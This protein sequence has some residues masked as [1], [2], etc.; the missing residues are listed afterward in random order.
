MHV[1]LPLP[2]RRAPA[3]A[4][5]LPLIVFGLGLAPAG[6][7]QAQPAR[8]AVQLP[9]VTVPGAAP[10]E[11]ATG[12]VQG[13]VAK[14][15]ATATKTDTP[16]LETPQSITVITRDRMSLLGAQTVRDAANYTAGVDSSVVTDTTV[17]W[18]KI[19]GTTASQYLDGMISTVAHYNNTRVDPYALERMEV[20]RGP[21]GMLFGQGALGGSVNLI[22][23]R[24]KAEAAREI[25][26]SYGNHDRKQIQAD[27]TGPLDDEG[28]WLY[29]LVALGRD[30]GSE[31][32]HS[33]DNRMFVA[34]SLTW[35]P[36]AATSFTLL[37]NLQE[38]DAGNTIGYFPWVGTVTPTPSGAIDRSTFVGEPDFNTM[39][40]RQRAVG[41][42]FEHAFND[43]LTVRQHLRYIRS[44][45]KAH[46]I[47]ATGWV[48][49][50]DRLL[51]RSLL[52]SDSELSYWVVDNQA[53]L[54]L[55][56]GPVNHTV[57]TGLDYQNSNT[58]SHR[59]LGGKAEPIDAFE[60]VY[61]RYTPP[62]RVSDS[63]YHTGQMGVYAQEQLDWQRWLLTL[64]LRHDSYRTSW[65]QSVHALTKRFGLMYR[66]A[67]GLNPYLSY[68]ES[69]EG[70]SGTNI[71]GEPYKPLRGNQWEAGIK[72]QPPGHNL[73]VTAAIFDMKERNRKVPGLVNGIPTQVQTGLARTRGF[74]LE[75]LASQG[76][77]DLI[78]NYTYLDARITQGK[79]AEQGH[80]LASIARHMA[81]LWASYRFRVLGAPGFLAGA[82][83]RYNGS[84]SDGA[85]QHGLPPVMVY[86]AVLA[87]DAGQ[88]RM[89]LNLNNLFDKRYLSSC[90]ASGGC[91]YG[92]SRN[93]VGSVTYRF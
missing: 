45:R 82:G 72:Y 33:K 17:D 38:D 62:T 56:S 43:Q 40:A 7:A 53:Q 32:R 5:R 48:R 2:A 50:S 22:S 75:A 92:A 65:M 54:K 70:N 18:M 8:P 27:I 28:T 10:D 14:R 4:W 39:L 90:Q 51:N 91:Y 69:F 80:Q 77:L 57:L 11:T 6:A 19:R 52:A 20:L 30:S 35:K 71:L 59:G 15:T 24:P 74:E 36:S 89:A 58:I 3:L 47:S 46:K 1:R 79:P 78:A 61:G 26:V 25:G 60:P 37:G 41:Y 76:D 21:A 64:G 63:V 23:K 13:F 42:Q 67:A 83:A 34:P 87:Y 12:P 55:H 68:T 49:G 84:R 85:G 31:V 44:M 81:S 29:R 88:M 86:D 66:S 93:V 9:A 73:T 16:V